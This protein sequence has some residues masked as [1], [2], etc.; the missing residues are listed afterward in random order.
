MLRETS[1]NQETNGDQGDQC[2]KMNVVAW[3]NGTKV[4]MRYLS[5]RIGS[6][7]RVL[8]QLQQFSE[9]LEKFRWGH[10]LEMAIYI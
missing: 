10:N 5:A 2:H 4:I 8:V 3:T 1:G 6:V 9:S 7:T